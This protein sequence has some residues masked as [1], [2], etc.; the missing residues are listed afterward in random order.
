MTLTYTM[1]NSMQIIIV[2]KS[3]LWQAELWD[4]DQME[5]EDILLIV[6]GQEKPHMC[7]WPLNMYLLQNIR[8][9]LSEVS[10]IHVP[11]TQLYWQKSLNVFEA[12]EHV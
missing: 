6:A 3:T 10:F 7:I 9:E 5:T 11:A 8:E 4:D 2:C 12:R 1:E